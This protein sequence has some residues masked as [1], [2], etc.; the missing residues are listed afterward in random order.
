MSEITIEDFLN[1]EYSQTALYASFRSIASYIDGLKP[2]SRKIVYTLKKK[3]IIND[4]KVSRLASTVSELTEYLHGEGSLQGVI[5]NMAQT[6]VGSNNDALLYPAGSFGTRFVP[7]ASAPRYIFTRKSESFDNYFSKEDDEI[8]IQQEFEGTIIEPKFFV[9]VLPLLLINGSEGIGTGFAQKILPRNKEEIKKYINDYLTDPS[10]VSQKPLVPF[11]AGFNG[12]ILQG[13]ELGSW[14][15]LGSYRIKDITTIII[16]EIPIGYTLSTYTKVLDSLEE[17]KIIL[18]FEDKSE[19]DNFLFEVKVSKEFTKQSNEK[20]LDDL[21][22]VKRVTE[23]YTCVAEDNSIR[24]FNSA[25][26]II[27]AYIEVRLE[28]YKKRKQY[29][30]SIY[31]EQLSEI[32]SK[33]LFISEVINNNIYVNNTP[34]AQI[35]SQLTS[36]EDIIEV[37]GSYDYL[38]NMPIYSLTKEKYEELQKKA[39]DK[40]AQIKELKLKSE[41]DLWKEDLEK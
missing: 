2:S 29:L 37:N 7:I 23:N 17:R 32:Q 21:K 15:I 35:L 34:K 8:L 20:I 5:S 36:Y 39:K 14:S 11:Y 22:L 3:N 1:D 25:E 28:Y 16:D 30:L 40:K 10:K 13:E 27:K 19:N 33:A 38:L 18:S 4:V 9:P 31:S 24:E 12:T 26:E 6:F 41:K